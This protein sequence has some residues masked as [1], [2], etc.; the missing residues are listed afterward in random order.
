MVVGWTID[1]SLTTLA[2]PNE[3]VKQVEMAP[4]FHVTVYIVILTYDRFYIHVQPSQTVSHNIAT[5]P[6]I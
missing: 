2:L 6:Y 1:P 3:S 4:L 5:L